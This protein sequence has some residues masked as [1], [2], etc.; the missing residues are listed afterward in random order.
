MDSQPQDGKKLME[1][2][3][4]GQIDESYEKKLNELCSIF[5]VFFLEKVSKD[6]GVK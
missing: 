3:N 5:K 1:L 2:W 4:L 6:V